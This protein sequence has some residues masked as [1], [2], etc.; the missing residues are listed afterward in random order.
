VREFLAKQGAVTAFYAAPI[1]QGGENVTIAE[2][3]ER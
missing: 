3:G 2:L 1:E